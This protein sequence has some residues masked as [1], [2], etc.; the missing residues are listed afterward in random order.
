MPPSAPLLVQCTGK[1]GLNHSGEEVEALTF[2]S[3]E[4][5]APLSG[6][7]VSASREEGW[8]SI[9]ASV[10]EA[11][12]R[13]GVFCGVRPPSSLFQAP[14]SLLSKGAWLMGCVNSLKS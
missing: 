10:L 2:T 7:E 8:F 14:V 5:C 4:Y 6:A 11:S 9:E 3:P 13:L 1:T 12:N